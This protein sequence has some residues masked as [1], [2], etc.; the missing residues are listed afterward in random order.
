MGEP[1]IYRRKPAA[2]GLVYLY[3]TRPSW[4]KMCRRYGP[5]RPEVADLFI[6]DLERFYGPAKAPQAE[7]QAR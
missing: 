4:G 6:E 7:A 2:D 3:E 1:I 5:M